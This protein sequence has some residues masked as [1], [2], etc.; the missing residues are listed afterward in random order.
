MLSPFKINWNGFSSLDKDL[1]CELSFGGNSGEASSFLSR[2][3]VSTERFNGS[4]RNIYN[5]KYNEVLTPQI[6]LIKQ[7]YSDFSHEE[8]RQILSWLTSSNKPGWLEVFHDDSEVVSYRLWGNWTSIEQYKLGN[9]RVVGYV[10]TFESSSPMAFSPKYE[11]TKQISG[12]N[13]FTINCESDDY[14][15][16]LYPKVSITFGINKNQSGQY[17]NDNMYF[18]V[19]VNPLSDATY[20]MIP[21]VIYTYD[22]TLYVNVVNDEQEVRVAVLPTLSNGVVANLDTV[23][24]YYYFTDNNTIN[25]VIETKLDNGEYIYNLKK[26]CSV[27][28]A[29]QIDN[30]YFINGE[31][32]KTSTIVSGGA[33][34][35]TLT[36]DG[37]N[38]VISSD[39]DILKIMGDYFNWKWLPLA[40]ET[41]TITITGN[42]IVKIE[43]IEPRKV[44]DL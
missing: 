4:Y 32:V 30:E 2:E 22:D 29:V 9:S 40:N 19:T 35:D 1:W 26:L 11:V 8:N 37:T 17:T 27:T 36:L 14:N 6:T 15:K 31:T 33:L 21:N 18:P 12:I 38:K 34:G 23:G 39:Q 28:A 7:D 20:Y 42:C 25:T 41:N 3:A 24:K 43:W 16:V 44:G 5:Y 10:C 13:S